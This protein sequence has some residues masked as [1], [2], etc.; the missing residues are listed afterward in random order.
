[1]YS[2]LQQRFVQCIRFFCEVLFISFVAS[3]RPAQLK[4]AF[5]VDRRKLNRINYKHWQKWNEQNKPA[6]VCVF[7]IH[8]NRDLRLPSSSHTWSNH[9]MYF[10]SPAWVC[11]LDSL[12]LNYNLFISVET[13]FSHISV[14]TDLLLNGVFSNS[15]QRKPLCFKSNASVT[16]WLLREGSLKLTLFST[17]WLLLASQN[18]HL[19]RYLLFFFRTFPRRPCLALPRQPRASFARKRNDATK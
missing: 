11:F 15:S 3:S 7:Q 14:E 9:L 2:F 19:Q 6:I 13:H 18:L 16:Q 4:N 12:L 8:R 5:A 1:M 17:L 10:K